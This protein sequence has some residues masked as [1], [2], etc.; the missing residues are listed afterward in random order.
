MSLGSLP[1]EP[2]KPI[3]SVVQTQNA[4]Y[5]LLV[6]F[7]TDCVPNLEELC[8]LQEELFYQGMTLLT[9]ACN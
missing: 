1:S 4:A 9:Q 6:A 8:R 5:D 2:V 3:C 7:V